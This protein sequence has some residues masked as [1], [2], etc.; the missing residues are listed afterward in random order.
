MPDKHLVA[1][2]FMLGIGLVAC[3]P[4]EVWTPA[5]STLAQVAPTAIHEPLPDLMVYRVEIASELGIP[6]LTRSP[7]WAS[8]SGFRNSGAGDATPFSV[9]VN[10]ADQPVE[11]ILKPGDDVELWFAGYSSIN[12]ISLDV[13]SQV[14]ESDESNNIEYRQLPVP[15]ISSA[16]LP[17]VEPVWDSQNPIANLEGHVGKVWS[18]AFSP[19]GGLIASVG[20]ITPYACGG[21]TPAACCE[22]CRDIPF[23]IRS[24]AFYA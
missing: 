6:A 9:S 12:E 19:D 2:L 18:I 3:Q 16:C 1:F 10:H 8:I 20:S 13:Y 17:E 21:L 5:T 24:M 7:A 23:P 22:P 4:V 14:R 15:T 11:T